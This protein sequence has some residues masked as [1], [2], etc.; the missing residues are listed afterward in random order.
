MNKAQQTALIIVV[1]MIGL[2]GGIFLNQKLAQKDADVSQPES[3]APQT[4]KV[5]ASERRPDFALEDLDGKLRHT[6]EWDGQV[7]MVNFWATWCPP[8]VREMP[9]FVKLYEDYKDKGFVVLGIAIDEKQAIIDFADPIGVDYPI[10]LAE[11]SG[12]G[13]SQDYGNRLGILPYTVF[14]DRQGKI[15]SRHPGEVTYEQAE[16]IIKPLL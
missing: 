3:H 15:I 12:V 2:A 5:E 4:T 11:Q 14:I 8:C 10:L 13:I 7:I 16:E 9:A 6:R 1:A